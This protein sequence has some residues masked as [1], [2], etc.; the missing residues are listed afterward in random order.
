MFW[1]AA[2]SRLRKPE[3]EGVGD[4]AQRLAAKFGGERYKRFMKRIG[5]PCACE[6]RQA[7][8][9]QLYRYE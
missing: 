4:T 5:A 7:E 9:N 8:W 3:D 6:K 2:L 1:V